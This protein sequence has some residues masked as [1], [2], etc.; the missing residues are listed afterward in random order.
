M[1]GG[2][3]G[4]EKRLEVRF[5]PSSPLNHSG[6][7]ELSREQL[8]QL[9]GQVNCTILSACS[10]EQLDSYVLSESSL[11]VYS[12]RLVL[13]TCGTTTLLRCLPLLMSY[14]KELDLAVSYVSYSRRNF[15]FPERQLFPHCSFENE[16]S[17][18]NA[19]FDG[20]AFILG[21][22][23]G[24]HWHLYVADMRNQAEVESAPSQVFEMMM[25]GLHASKMKQFYR[26]ADKSEEGK[27]GAQ[28]AMPLNESSGLTRIFPSA[29]MD[30][31]LFE[32]CGYSMNGIRTG[33]YATVHVTPEPECS[34]VSYET[35]EQ[36]A[37]YQQ[38]VEQLVDAFVPTEF[39]VVVLADEASK[40]KEGQ[41]A[42]KGYKAIFRTSHQ[43]EGVQGVHAVS[44]KRE[45]MESSRVA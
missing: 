7:R 43:L 5:R 23:T 18:L 26:K 10:N 17:T 1:D 11:F 22:L 36:R 38:L 12:H 21:P 37:D 39:T 24:A 29:D 42:M 27:N 41:L 31:F 8:D 45:R 4:P 19:L 32:P 35:N 28:L 34:F 33:E 20:Q 6:L 16:V 2:F 9:C 25:T 13:K 15:L 40:W 44:F 30:A 3:E 14:A